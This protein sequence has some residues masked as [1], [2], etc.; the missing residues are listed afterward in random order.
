MYEYLLQKILTY[1]YLLCTPYFTTYSMFITADY[2][3]YEY[4]ELGEFQRDG[5]VSRQLKQQST[6]QKGYLHHVV[7]T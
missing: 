5:R 1:S 4:D 2:V 7:H 6:A 3:L